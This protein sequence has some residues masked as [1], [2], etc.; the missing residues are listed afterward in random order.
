MMEYKKKV[1]TNHPVQLQITLYPLASG[2][3]GLR[4]DSRISSA[5]LQEG[6]EASSPPHLWGSAWHR[7]RRAPERQGG[8]PLRTV[9]PL[10]HFPAFLSSVLFL[11]HKKIPSQ[12]ISITKSPQCVWYNKALNILI[13]TWE[14]KCLTLSFLIVV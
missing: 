2:W 11:H 8:G 6:S 4:A 14:Y 12:N 1:E 3:E 13:K 7:K 5:V 9:A 10:P